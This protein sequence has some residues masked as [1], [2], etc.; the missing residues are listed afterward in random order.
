MSLPFAHLPIPSA[1]DLRRAI[2]SIVTALDLPPHRLDQ[3]WAPG[4]AWT[5]AQMAWHLADAESV[6]LDR[7]CRLIAEEQPILLPFDEDR[8][9]AL[10]PPRPMSHLGPWFTA[11]RTV[12]A[13]VVEALSAGALERSAPHA[14]FG[15]MTLADVLRHL[16]GHALHHAAQLGS[17]SATRPGMS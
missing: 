10:L 11:T 1:D 5:C 12:L 14:R 7:V 4:K 2:P 16:H 3:P 6:H 9:C 15:R 13:D 8:W 17:P